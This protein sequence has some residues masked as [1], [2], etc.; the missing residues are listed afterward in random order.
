MNIYK[1]KSFTKQITVEV[2][3]QTIKKMNKTIEKLQEMNL[4]VYIRSC[5]SPITK[6]TTGLLQWDYFMDYN[7]AITAAIKGLLMREMSMDLLDKRRCRPYNT[8]STK[9]LY[10]GTFFEEA[11]IPRK[12]IF[13][14]FYL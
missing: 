11:R 6:S 13:L 1:V 10:A 5:S 2:I 3:Q 4:Q 12:K 7:L 14:L 9:G 8:K